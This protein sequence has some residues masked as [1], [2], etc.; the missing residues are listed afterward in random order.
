MRIAMLAGSL[1]ARLKGID[2]DAAH[3]YVLF[4]ECGMAVMLRRFT[5]YAGIM[6]QA[7]EVP[8]EQ[9][10]RVEQTRFRYHH[11]RVSY[12]LARGW[13]LP[14]PL[15][16]AILHHHEFK[17][18]GE[19]TPETTPADR[20]LVAFG[21]LAEQMVALHTHGGLCADWPLGESFVLHTLGIDADSIVRLA[22]ELRPREQ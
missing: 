15:S 3:T 8:G 7:D 11:A 16:E 4:R 1:A 2:R 21:L 10:M 20:K 19:S 18:L 12:A 17:L 6:E 5:D 22:Q 14:D 13:F 9:L